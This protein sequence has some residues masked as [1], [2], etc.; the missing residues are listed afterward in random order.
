MSKIKEKKFYIVG[1]IDFEERESEKQL[2]GV[3]VVRGTEEMKIVEINE[4]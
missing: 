1:Y 2:H 3:L 4:E